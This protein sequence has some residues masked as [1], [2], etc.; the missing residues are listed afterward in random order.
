MRPP[1]YAGDPILHPQYPRIRETYSVYNAYPNYGVRLDIHE[2]LTPGGSFYCT[3]F[4]VAEMAGTDKSRLF[5]S[6][7]RGL[8]RC[9][10]PLIDEKANQQ[11]A[12]YT[13]R[14]GFQTRPGDEATQ[15]MFDVK[16]LDRVVESDC[17]VMQA[18]QMPDRASIEEF[19]SVLV[20][21]DLLIELVPK[22][23]M[24]DIDR[25]PI[26]NFVEVIREDPGNH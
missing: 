8:M 18:A 23:E 11:P 16:L 6:G 9:E 15:R 26:F 14:L 3:D 21:G 13:V 4:R 19:R 17:D 10:L 22:A 25:V 20:Q 1:R 5:A 12:T 7:C 24:P 2:K